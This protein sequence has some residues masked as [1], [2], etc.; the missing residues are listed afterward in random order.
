[1]CVRTTPSDARNPDL[2]WSQIRETVMMLSLALA[3]I[4]RSMTDGDDS[5]NA[6]TELF[7]R[8]EGRL[9]TQAAYDAIGGAVGA[10]ANRAESRSRS[11]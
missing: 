6:L 5:V 3:Q 11:S 2:D 9:I 4:E 1:M 10:L 8:R 7:D